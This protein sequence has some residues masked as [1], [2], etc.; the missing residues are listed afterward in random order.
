MNATLG[1]PMKEQAE[2][3]YREYKEYVTVC[4]DEYHAHTAAQGCLSGPQ[5]SKDICFLY[6]YI[7]V[8]ESRLSR[9][10]ELI[11]TSKDS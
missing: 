6:E 7:M 10:A 5:A 9:I 4:C 2:K 8:L 1:I 11:N 3:I